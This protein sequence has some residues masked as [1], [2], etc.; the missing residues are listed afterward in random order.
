MAG[1]DGAGEMRKVGWCRPGK[2]LNAG[3]SSAQPGASLP[4][5]RCGLRG[6][7][8]GGECGLPRRCPAL[9]PTRASPKRPAPLS[10]KSA[11]RQPASQH[12]LGVGSG[13]GLC[14]SQ[15]RAAREAA[16]EPE[17]RAGAAGQEAAGRAPSGPG[18]LTWHN[19]RIKAA[20]LRLEEPAQLS[21]RRSL[22]PD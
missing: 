20:Q 12:S 5:P 10:R 9:V 6:E 1:G 3:I 8:R 14:S 18:K 21:S 13:R 17:H 22:L 16:L 15:R 19:R 7:I 4:V 11:D 2:A